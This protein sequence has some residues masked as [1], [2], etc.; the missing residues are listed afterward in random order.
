MLSKIMLVKCSKLLS[1][2]PFAYGYRNIIPVIASGNCWTKFSYVYSK[3][4]GIR[5]CKDVLRVA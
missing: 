2:L 3:G 1:T 5:C 4:T